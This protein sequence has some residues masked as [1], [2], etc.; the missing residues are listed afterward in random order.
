MKIWAQSDVWLLRK[1]FV[2]GW[3]VHSR[4]ESLQVLFGL[5]TW[6]WIVTIFLLQE[7]HGVPGE[8]EVS[9]SDAGLQAGPGQGAEWEGAPQAGVEEEE[10]RVCREEVWHGVLRCRHQ[11][12]EIKVKTLLIVNWNFVIHPSS[13]SSW[14]NVPSLSTASCWC[15]PW[16]QWIWIICS[17]AA[18]PSLSQH[19]S[20]FKLIQIQLMQLTHS[21]LFTL[22]CIYQTILTSNL[23]LATSQLRL[24]T[25]D[26]DRWRW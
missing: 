14:S 4:I 20:V 10:E 23:N 3:V 2:G 22:S 7:L 1:V 26:N 6:T 13:C 18:E 11:V 12:W 15:I 17:A 5:W 19:F 8:W 9:G 24:M 25:L 16:T 21:G